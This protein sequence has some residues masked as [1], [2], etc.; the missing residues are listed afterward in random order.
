MSERRHLL[1][2]FERALVL[3]LGPGAFRPELVGD[4]D[5][6]LFTIEGGVRLLRE[7]AV[8]GQT[9]QAEK[10]REHLYLIEFFLTEEL[11]L[12]VD[13]LLPEIRAAR[14][15]SRVATSQKRVVRGGGVRQAAK[16]R[17]RVR[18]PRG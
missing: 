8:D 15:A 16:R 18:R 12:I 9:W 6:L 17:Q 10:M 4:L 5:D 11:P 7:L 1:D 14:E 13:D 3:S 2:A